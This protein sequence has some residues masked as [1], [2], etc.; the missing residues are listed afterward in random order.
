[1]RLARRNCHGLLPVPSLPP[2]APTQHDPRACLLT[3][4]AQ[5][6][7][8]LWKL[9]TFVSGQVRATCGGTFSTCRC[10]GVLTQEEYRKNTGTL[11]TCRHRSESDWPRQR[12]QIR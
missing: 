8:I 11:K 4:A 3:G 6:L 10:D 2:Y 9:D 7:T 12:Q 1:M 5:T